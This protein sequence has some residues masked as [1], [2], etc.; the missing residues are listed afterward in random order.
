MVAIR[1]SRY[2]VNTISSLKSQGKKIEVPF[3][4][5][6][7]PGHYK[8]QNPLRWKLYSKIKMVV[9]G[10]IECSDF[11]VTRLRNIVL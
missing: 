3:C 1:E 7:S 11:F 6:G 10:H 5:G 2:Q 8:F 9:G 4:N